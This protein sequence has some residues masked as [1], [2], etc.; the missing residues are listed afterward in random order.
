[1]T[2]ERKSRLRGNLSRYIVLC[3]QCQHAFRPSDTCPPASF[4]E[5]CRVFYTPSNRQR[6]KIFH[7]KSRLKKVA[8]DYDREL[9]RLRDIVTQL[10]SERADVQTRIDICTSLASSPMRRL[11][12]PLLQ[13]KDSPTLSF[14]RHDPDKIL[15]RIFTSACYRDDDDDSNSHLQWLTPLVMPHVC[16]HWRKLSL[17]IPEMWSY[18]DVSRDLHPKSN[19][20]LLHTYIAR[21]GAN[22]PLSV[23]VELDMHCSFVRR[24]VLNL[25]LGHAGRWKEAIIIVDHQLLF[26]F[27]SCP[28]DILERLVLRIGNIQSNR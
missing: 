28:L 1:M 24:H 21:T 25:L 26:Q 4:A 10:D 2:E 16:S 8:A 14:E 7:E 19:M 18:L 22:T 20:E 17:D 23:R 15:K 12:N 13:T 6:K 11:R 5:Q 3:D 9:T 27:L